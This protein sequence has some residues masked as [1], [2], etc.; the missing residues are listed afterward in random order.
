MAYWIR[1][2]L[3]GAWR[4]V[5]AQEFGRLRDEVQRSQINYKLCDNFSDQHE[6][7]FCGDIRLGRACDQHIEGYQGDGPPHLLAA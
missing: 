1:E 5:S 6:L 2:G 4:Q 3:G 7:S